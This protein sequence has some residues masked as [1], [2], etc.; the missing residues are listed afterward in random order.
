VIRPRGPLDSRQVPLA[1]PLSVTEGMDGRVTSMMNRLSPF[2]PPFSRQCA[3][4]SILAL[5]IIRGHPLSNAFCEACEVF[6]SFSA[7]RYLS[8]WNSHERVSGMNRRQSTLQNDG[9]NS[10]T[11]ASRS[12]MAIAGGSRPR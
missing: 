4:V 1:K 6:V 7:S 8:P 11:V 5:L 3:F 2:L 9:R 10:L 12:W